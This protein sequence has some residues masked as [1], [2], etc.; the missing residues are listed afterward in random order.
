MEWSVILIEMIHESIM[1]IF[2]W[3]EFNF[4]DVTHDRRPRPKRN[5]WNWLRIKSLK[6]EK[7]QFLKK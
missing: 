5:Q 7:N 6:F 2:E 3:I 1:E 4:N